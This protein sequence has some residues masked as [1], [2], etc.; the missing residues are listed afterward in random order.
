[1]DFSLNGTGIQW[2]TEA[3][4]GVNL[5]ILDI[6]LSHVSC[7]HCGNILVSSTRDDRFA[8]MTNIFVIEFGENIYGK[9]QIDSSLAFAEKFI[10]LS[11]KSVNKTRNSPLEFRARS[12]IEHIA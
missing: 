8:G 3:L 2:I 1:M 5:N 11:K 4:I 9:V 10:I 6:Y 12:H 7:W